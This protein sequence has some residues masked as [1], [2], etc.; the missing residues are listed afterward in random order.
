MRKPS[1]TSSS[2]RSALETAILVIITALL[3]ACYHI[4]SDS[5]SASVDSIV[6]EG[7]Q[8]QQVYPQSLE[9]P[10]PIEGEDIRIYAG[11]TSSYNH[12][13]LVPNWVAYELTAAEVEGEYSFKPSFSRDPNMEGSQASREDYSNSGWDKGHMAPRADMKW[14]EES[15]AESYYF[16]N[17]CPQNHEMNA[18]DWCSIEKLARRM[19]TEHGSV[20]VVCGPVFTTHEYGTIGGNQVNVPDA[21]FKA[22]LMKVDGT[23]QSIAFLVPNRPDRHPIHEYACT[24]NDIESL[25]GINLFYNLDDSVEEDIESTADMQTWDITTK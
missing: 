25:L 1:I 11:Y 16:T 8:S 9:F 2:T 3:S 7:S 19:A 15:L 6:V 4:P 21:F 24:V 18:Y 10:E 17:V 13:T 12:S 14:S 20:Y 23:Y 5:E 22:L